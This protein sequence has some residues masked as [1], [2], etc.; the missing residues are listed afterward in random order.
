MY[1]IFTLHN[2]KSDLL[3]HPHDFFLEETVT[4]LKQKESN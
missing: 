3:F 4:T 2:E 1:V